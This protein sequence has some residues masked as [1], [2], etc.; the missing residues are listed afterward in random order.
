M[1]M[2]RSTGRFLN[3]Y[4]HVYNFVT[5]NLFLQIG[6]QNSYDTAAARSFC[7]NTACPPWR[8]QKFPEL[9]ATIIGIANKNIQTAKERSWLKTLHYLSSSWTHAYTDGLAINATTD[10]GAG[11]LLMLWWT[12]ETVSSYWKVDEA[13]AFKTEVETLMAQEVADSQVVLLTDAL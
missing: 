10:G 7:L 11:V 4:T 5:L 13:E 1:L 2:H 12:H 3:R 9:K 6:V 8:K